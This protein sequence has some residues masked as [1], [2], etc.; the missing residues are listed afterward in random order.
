MGLPSYTHATLCSVARGRQCR[1]KVT[2]FREAG[3]ICSIFAEAAQR[4]HRLVERR[5]GV[6]LEPGLGG[7][8][9]LQPA[10]WATDMAGRHPQVR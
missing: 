7:L 8:P 6:R 2:G 10:A 1:G 3:A 5:L 9:R 4:H